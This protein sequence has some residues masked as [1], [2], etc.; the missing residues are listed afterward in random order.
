MQR[1]CKKC[2][3]AILADREE[4]EV[5]H[6]EMEHVR[7][8]QSVEMGKQIQL[9]QQLSLLR[10]QSSTGDGPEIERLEALLRE[11]ERRADGKQKRYD[12]LHARLRH[13]E[14]L[15]EGGSHRSRNFQRN[16]KRSDV[17]P[18]YKTAYSK[19]YQPMPVSPKPDR[20]NEL[21]QEDQK[22]TT[23]KRNGNKRTTNGIR[24]PHQ[25][26]YLFE[27]SHCCSKGGSRK[28]VKFSVS[29]GLLRGR[30]LG[31]PLCN[32][33]Q[34]PVRSWVGAARGNSNEA[35]IRKNMQR[36]H[37]YNACR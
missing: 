16:R 34:S 12:L 31:L 23:S 10:L 1:V 6:S 35:K 21:A 30:T 3:R 11:Q 13:L 4:M 29:S 9:Q 25:F 33:G 24:L 14:A 37:G 15:V 7:A 32:Y 28:F 18:N 27:R 2:F 22:R 8:L 20:L 17:T 5:L 26:Q 36:R 19:D